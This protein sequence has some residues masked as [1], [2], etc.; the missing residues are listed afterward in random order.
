MTHTVDVLAI[1]SPITGVEIKLAFVVD[2]KELTP[3]DVERYYVWKQEGRFDKIVVISA[4]K[5]DIEAY[6]LAKRFG[7][8]IVRAGRDVEVK[9]SE[10]G[11]YEVVHVHPL[12][13]KE[14]AIAALKK[15]EKGF[16][17]RK[18]KLVATA[19]VYVPF[20]EIETEAIIRG[21]EEEA[22]EI[23]L[24]SLTFDGIKGT[25]VIE[26]GGSLKPIRERGSY[27]ELSDASLD[28]LRVLVKDGYK[29][30]S[31]LVMELKLGEGKVKAVA[32]FL[33]NKALVDVYSDVIEI[34]KSLFSNT[35]S[36]VKMIKEKGAVM[37]EGE[38]PT[39]K[40][41]LVIFPRIEM[42]RLLAFIET[43]S[44]KIKGITLIYYPFYVGFIEESSN[45]ETRRMVVVDGLT[46]SEAPSMEWLLTY[47]EDIIEDIAFERVSQ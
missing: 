25:L 15:H 30:I 35:L 44:R 37:H 40:G 11:Q 21:P 18:G 45:G 10:L 42:D 12:I 36:L 8:D 47:V 27:S 32:N 7:V 17:K 6:E 24:I 1:L 28:V 2:Y 9:Y 29:T 19:L 5:V 33:L 31:D 43:F 26:E 13:S 41:E 22:G 34:R 38:P 20:F 3:E 4:G 23:K 14:V 16:L 46:C 39:E